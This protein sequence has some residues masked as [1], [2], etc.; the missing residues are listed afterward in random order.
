M[1]EVYNG[2]SEKI[3]EAEEL[4]LP[5]KMGRIEGQTDYEYLSKTDLKQENYFTS[6]YKQYLKRATD[7]ISDL[8]RFQTVEISKEIKLAYIDNIDKAKSLINI[9]KLDLLKPLNR[10][11]K[12]LGEK[13]ITDSSQ[14]FPELTIE[15]IE[16]DI[17][18]DAWIRANKFVQFTS[19]D[20][21]ENEIFDNMVKPLVAPNEIQEVYALVLL[22]LLKQVELTEKDIFGLAPKQQKIEIADNLFSLGTAPEKLLY[23]KYSGLYESIKTTCVN[24][25][26]EFVKSRAARYIAHLTNESAA[27]IET[28]LGQLDYFNPSVTKNTPYRADSVRNTIKALSEIGIDTSEL[29]KISNHFERE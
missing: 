6:H 2:I 20:I 27:N 24:K 5:D 26:G 18:N 3:K 29:E 12:Q 25:R 9:L 22:Y 15:D 10:I 4:F 23:L 13:E 8:R 28:L 11:L 14:I 16:S 19:D 21:L 7:I 1:A 17:F